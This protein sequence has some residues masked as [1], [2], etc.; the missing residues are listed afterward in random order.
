MKTLPIAATLLLAICAPPVLA[1]PAPIPCMADTPIAAVISFQ[2]V[3]GVAQWLV[4]SEYRTAGYLLEGSQMSGDSWTAVGPM[5]APGGST[6]AVDVVGTGFARFR[7]V[8]VE[9]GGAKR[10][11][12]V[13]SSPCRQLRPKDLGRQEQHWSPNSTLLNNGGNRPA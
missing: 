12:G 7:L 3:D 13:E 10:I 11:I 2:I 8:E 9:T 5:Q 6:Y 1:Y 4:S